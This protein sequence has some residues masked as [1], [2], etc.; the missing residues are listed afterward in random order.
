VRAQ[1]CAIPVTSR[2]VPGRPGRRAYPAGR[3]EPGRPGRSASLRRAAAVSHELLKPHLLAA[4]GTARRREGQ[5]EH[6][7]SAIVRRPRDEVRDQGR[8]PCS[9]VT[10]P[11]TGTVYSN[12]IPPGISP[13]AYPL[14]CAERRQGQRVPGGHPGYRAAA[15]V[16][17]ALQAAG[18]VRTKGDLRGLGTRA[19]PLIGA[20]ADHL[21][22]QYGE[23]RRVIRGR[24]AAYPARLSLGRRSAPN[25]RRVTIGVG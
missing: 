12:E 6:A 17:E 19:D 14:W 5:N 7:R 8:R 24:L 2:A 15:S 21:V 18:C 23:Q 20:A 16:D 3:Y 11:R 13:A 9:E 22:V 4:P 25:G 10:S 1:R